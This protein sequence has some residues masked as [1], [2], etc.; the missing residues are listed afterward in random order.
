MGIELFCVF[1][2]HDFFKNVIL[3]FLI[4][5]TEND[6]LSDN[7]VDTLLEHIKIFRINKFFIG[8]FGVFELKEEFQDKVEMFVN[9]ISGEQLAFGFGY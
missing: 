9:K 7:A 5:W 4:L 3:D 8:L 1:F 2:I 6:E